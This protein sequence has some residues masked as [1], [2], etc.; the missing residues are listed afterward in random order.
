MKRLGVSQTT[1][2][3]ALL[4]LSS[5]A[6]PQLRDEAAVR[7][8]GTPIG[9]NAISKLVSNR[10]WHIDWAGCMGG[11]NGCKTYWDFFANGTLCARGI[12]AKRQDKCADDG[13]WQIKNNALCWEL[14]W[15]GGDSG[16]K[17]TCILVK[18][19]SNEGYEATRS[20]GIGL[21]MFRFTLTKD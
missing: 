14:T 19:T 17:S 3:I 18:T 1:T 7:A 5:V 13:K 15:M 16:Y 9:G 8:W 12:N 2:A 10:T 21:T 11:T 4:L 6:S 20:H